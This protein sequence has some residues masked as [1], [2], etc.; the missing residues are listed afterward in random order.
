MIAIASSTLLFSGCVT[1]PDTFSNHNGYY[2][3][4]PRV[5][6][7]LVSYGYPYY[8]D[9]PYYF[10]NGIYYYGGYYRNG[11]YHYGDRRFRHGH[12]YHRG[13]R[14]YN[15]RRYVARSG[16]YGY[17]KNRDDYRRSH[18]YRKHKKVK[19]RSVDR[20]RVY[21]RT[22]YKRPRTGT[23][24][25]NRQQHTR[26][27]KVKRDRSSYVG[28]GQHTMR[29]HDRHTSRSTTRV[30]SG[31]RGTTRQRSRPVR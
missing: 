4:A 24:K 26:T 7:A 25:Q 17:Y 1:Q 15:G 10:F 22:K 21:D 14:Y 31:V 29:T 30:Q 13:H 27:K 2:N 23:V 19:K 5:N 6:V 18:Q 12:Y 8:Y 11:Y 3:N 20:G 16:A 28:S 9:R